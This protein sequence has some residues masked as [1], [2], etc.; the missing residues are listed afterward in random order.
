MVHTTTLA[1][2]RRRCPSATS[3]WRQRLARR[4]YET[5]TRIWGF[6]I[7][8]AHRCRFRPRERCS[9]LKRRPR[10]RGS[11]AMAPVPG[12]RRCPAAPPNELSNFSALT[13][14]FRLTRSS[15]EFQADE[16]ASIKRS[17]ATRSCARCGVVLS[18]RVARRM[19][20]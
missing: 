4:S 3:F 16:H 11:V 15:A 18:P 1:G 9:M 6:R 7:Y 20:C 17:R 10:S 13:S 19:A 12:T 5:S 2:R 14:R 8:A